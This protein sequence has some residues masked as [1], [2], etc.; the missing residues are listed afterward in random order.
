M[1]TKRLL[2]AFLALAVG[3]V[4]L[5]GVL[6]WLSPDGASAQEPPPAKG[7]AAID[8]PQDP[9]IVPGAVFTAFNGVALNE[10]ALYVFEAGTWRPIPFQIDEV[11]L[12]GTLVI[13]DDGLLDPND[14]LVFMAADAGEQAAADEWVADPLARL[15][16]RYAIQVTDPLS[17]AAQAWAYLYRSTA[18]PHSSNSYLTWDEAGQQVDAISY[19]AAFSPSM[20]GLAH[21]TINGIGVD[22]LD[23]QKIRAAVTLGPFTVSFD[24]ESL[25]SLGLI[26]PTIHLPAVGP[27]R[28]ATG[29]GALRAAF[30]GERYEFIFTVD[31]SALAGLPVDYITSTLDLRDPTL[32][33]LNTY[34]DSNTPA[35]VPIDGAPDPI[36]ATPPIDWYQVSGGPGGPGGFV[37]AIPQ[38]GAGGGSVANFYKDDNTFDPDDTGDGV[39]YANAGVGI[40][41]P[42]QVIS[43]TLTVSILPPGTATN[44][45]DTYFTWLLNP[46]G[47]TASIQHLP[48]TVPPPNLLFLPLLRRP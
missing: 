37:L 9:V 27:V 39:S 34:Y 7:P 43:M 23:R 11:D 18:L 19:T 26:T 6:A 46:P 36:P 1:E 47:A 32:T 48:P 31:T 45:G 3:I 12:S 33:G 35:G 42:G 13:S 22:V 10:F 4:A 14:E 40:D 5:W 41:Q 16:P 29:S 25:V 20:V 38:V 15:S 24:E 30:Y 44:M 8:R 17:S 21:M 2:N 28:A